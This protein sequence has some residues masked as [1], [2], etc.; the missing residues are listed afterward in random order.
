MHMD[1]VRIISSYSGKLALCHADSYKQNLLKRI[2]LQSESAAPET[3]L[4]N[5]LCLIVSN[6]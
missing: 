3:S 4:A 1:S 6:L 2:N 5:S